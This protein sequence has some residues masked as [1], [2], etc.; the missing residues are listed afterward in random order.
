MA[1]EASMTFSTNFKNTTPEISKLFQIAWEAAHAAGTLI[2]ENWQQPE[3]NILQGSHRLGRASSAT[4]DL[5][6]VACSRLDGFWE[7]KLR[8]WDTAAGS[9]MIVKGSAAAYATF[10]ATIFLSAATKPWHPT[11]QFIPRCL[12]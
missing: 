4:L 11:A 9:L 7:L 3:G 2:R 12:K 1:A 5:C 8:P 6:Y 10:P